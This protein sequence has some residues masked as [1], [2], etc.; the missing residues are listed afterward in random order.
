MY[1]KVNIRGNIVPL[2]ARKEYTLSVVLREACSGGLWTIFLGLK[3]LQA[4]KTVKTNCN[5][6]FLTFEAP[7]V[8][9]E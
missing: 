5:K 7:D 3:E 1:G 6:V 8:T 4:M 2:V 9:G